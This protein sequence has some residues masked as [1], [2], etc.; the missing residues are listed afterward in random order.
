MNS[1]FA[2]RV[3]QLVFNPTSQSSGKDVLVYIYLQG[4]MDGLNVVV[5]YGDVFYY[6]T[7]P[8]LR[9][10]LP[11]L[12]DNKSVI[13]LDGYFGFHPSLAPLKR[14]YD[15]GSL[16]IVHAVGMPDVTHS[17]NQALNHLESGSISQL[18]NPS[19]WIGRHLNTKIPAKPTPLRAVSFGS[20]L[21]GTLR[22]A[23]SAVTLQSLDSFGLSGR[24]ADQATYQNYLQ[25]LYQSPSAAAQLSQTAGET[26]QVLGLLDQMNTLDYSTSNYVNYPQS[27]FGKA[28]ADTYTLINANVGLEVACIEMGGWDNHIQEGTIYGDLSRQLDELVQG[29]TA[30]VSDLGSRMEHVLIMTV[31]E[32]GRRV[33][34][35]N[36]SGTDHGHGNAMFLM[37]GGVLGGKVYGT[38]PTLAP[39]KLVG[40]GDLAVTTDYRDVF[41]E[42]LKNRMGNPNAA[43]I[44][45]DYTPKPVGAT[46]PL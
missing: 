34:E 39:N 23:Q 16:A 37:G 24:V 27:T 31:S 21:S 6:Y 22:G 1:K 19:G 7:R 18:P 28:L 3:S 26:Q 38:W 8:T 33:A 30:F 44:F 20:T 36:S 46:R 13:D 10:Q 35:N 40:S 12:K 11:Y 14:F 15:D 5:P 29:I 17:H 9:I 43:A 32:F 25:S 45:P 4:G 42:V 2:S 41:A